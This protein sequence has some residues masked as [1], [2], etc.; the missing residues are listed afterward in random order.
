MNQDWKNTNLSFEERTANLVS[1][2]TLEEKVSQMT[3]S[4]GALPRFGIPEYNWWNECLHGVARAGVATVFPQ[5]IGLASMFD[6]E[7]MKKIA[8]VIS[9]EARIK[10][11]EA[12]AQ[13]D[14]GI[15]KGLTMAWQLCQYAHSGCQY[16]KRR[17][18]LCFRSFAGLFR[19]PGDAGGGSRSCPAVGVDLLGLVPS[20][21][22]EDPAR[23][24]VGV[25]TRG[26]EQ[27]MDALTCLKTRRSIRSYRPLQVEEE[28]LRQVLE[29]GTYAATCM[30]WQGV[31]MVVIQDR[32]TLNLLSR[33]N[34]EIMGIDGD[35]FYGAPT[36]IVVLV[37][38]SRG[39]WVED[40]ALVM[41]NLMNAA[42]AL[43]LGSCWV[44]RAREEF[45]SE[46]G[47]ALLQKWGAPEGYVG[48]AHCVL[49]Y[50]DG[51][52]PQPA[53]RR[54]DYILRI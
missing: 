33:M 21:I 49:G 37:D 6:E 52:A 54:E 14:H 12:E 4:S 15:Y 20:C 28:Q 42:H 45:D 34:A 30:G 3:Y 46:E 40:G 2:M 18:F 32:E 31:K 43:G 5:A 10:H 48:V 38:T 7:L 13:G 11:H 27:K 16:R 50:P 29:A 53:P 39:L 51:I 35:P 36:V 25:S 24:N 47:K 41:G 19:L 1:Q 44:H 9:D 8:S 23:I 26:K 22:Q 17:R